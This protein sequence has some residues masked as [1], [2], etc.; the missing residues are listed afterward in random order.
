MLQRVFRP[1][2][3]KMEVNFKGLV[4]LYLTQIDNLESA[5]AKLAANDFKTVGTLSSSETD[6]FAL[7]RSAIRGDTTQFLVTHSHR[8]RSSETRVRQT[9]FIA[10]LV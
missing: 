1:S 5:L 7:W 3:L 9:D 2:K 8:R 6:D 10:S 4:H